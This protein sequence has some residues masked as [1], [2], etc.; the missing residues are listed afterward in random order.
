MPSKDKYNMSGTCCRLFLV[1]SAKQF[2]R[3]VCVDFYRVGCQ[4]AS[5]TRPMNRAVGMN[6]P[7]WPD[8]V[9]AVPHGRVLPVVPE[10]SAKSVR[11][12]AAAAMPRRHH[13]PGLVPQRVDPG[14]TAGQPTAA[15]RGPH[16]QPRAGLV[17]HT[18][19]STTTRR[20]G[21]SHIHIHNHAQD[22][23]V[24]HPHLQ[25]R[26]G[27]VGH[28]STSTTTRRTGGSPTTTPTTMHRTGGTHIHTHNH[29]QDWWVTHP[30][31]QDWWVTHPHPQPRTGL[32]GH[33]S[34]PTT[35]HRTGGSLIHTHN[36][37]TMHRT[38]G[39]YT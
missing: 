8:P 37:S 17:G 22:W 5:M 39:S 11:H 33:S 24:T 14:V 25:P 35:T 9:V 3:T 15:L 12:A 30:H 27:L 38:G 28:T 4:H 16:P 34:T 2:D 32:V 26:A 31:P 18:S 21:G 7:R 19:T 36:Q 29:A 10:V 23:W 20:T 6:D 13:Q 1:I